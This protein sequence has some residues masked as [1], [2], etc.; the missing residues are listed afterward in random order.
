MKKDVATPLWET[1]SYY[2]V[3]HKGSLD[4][5]HPGM[6]ELFELAK[7]ARKILDLG[8]GDGTRLSLFAK[9]KESV[10]IDGSSKAISLALKKYQGIR[11]IKGNIEQLPFES[12]SFDLVYSAYVLEHLERPEKA[13][14]EALRV[15][16]PGGR[17]CLIAPNFGAPNRASPPFKGSR[18]RK[19]MKKTLSDF[20]PGARRQSLGWTKVRPIER[21]YEPDYDTTVEPYLGS[22]LRFLRDK[23]LTIKYSSS[24]W[25]QELP[26]VK[27]HQVFFRILGEAGLY[28]FN[29][30][31]PHLVVVGEKK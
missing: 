25:S 10:G 23:G 20:S 24:C 28:P 3:A 12:E 4:L 21:R 1:K 18:L 8:C 13:L 26:G 11:F 22:L 6:V 17:I 2:A 19:F 29:L 14:D 30:W 15:T 31:G 27:I 7:D 9:D 5:K 16:A